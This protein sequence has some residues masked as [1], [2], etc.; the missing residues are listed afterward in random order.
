VFGCR[1]VFPPIWLLLSPQWALRRSLGRSPSLFK[2]P[3]PALILC[4]LIRLT[5]STFFFFSRL[6]NARESP[7]LADGKASANDCHHGVDPFFFFLPDSPHPR[8]MYLLDIPIKSSTRSRFVFPPRFGSRARTRIGT[9]AFSLFSNLRMNARQPVFLLWY[10]FDRISFL[11]PTL[12]T[13][14][15]H[16]P[17]RLAI[18]ACNFDHAWSVQLPRIFLRDDQGPTDGECGPATPH[19]RRLATQ[20]LTPPPPPPPPSGSLRLEDSMNARFIPL[21][22]PAL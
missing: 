11:S 20:P 6:F 21:V 15:L 2:L 12:N 17:K 14:P 4:P 22:P 16:S 13:G 19:L 7:A 9:A 5:A 18:G 10:I 8:W 1:F 3:P